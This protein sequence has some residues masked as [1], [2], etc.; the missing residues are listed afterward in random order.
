[1]SS[2]TPEPSAKRRR[3][4]IANSTLKKPFKSPLINRPANVNV[5]GVASTPA[6]RAAR[7]GVG[8]N[9]L[10]STSSGSTK[11]DATSPSPL[12]LNSRTPDPRKRS[13]SPTEPPQ[14]HRIKEN[15]N[16][17]P[18]CD[19][20]RKIQRET[21]ARIRAVEAE[22]EVLEQAVRIERES[23]AKRPEEEIDAELKELVGKWKGASRMAAEE[24]FELIKG[25]VER[26]GGPKGIGLGKRGEGYYRGGDDDDDG[27]AEHEGEGDA[28][29]D[30]KEAEDESEDQVRL[31]MM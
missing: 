5:N 15:A 14:P 28:D 30:G 7:A 3:V 8:R 26:M 1:M 31:S 2:N 19:Q 18:F 29:G 23:K 24:L 25:R 20:F 22:L 4:E 13:T 9:S 21:A 6:P 11:Q 17:N 16:F 27:K 12:N 10:F